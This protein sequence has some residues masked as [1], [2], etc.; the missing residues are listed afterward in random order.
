MRSNL[1]CFLF[2]FVMICY[3]YIYIIST[4]GIWVI[5]YI[6]LIH[7]IF[8]QLQISHI[9]SCIQFPRI[10]SC[11]QFPRTPIS[12]TF[13]FRAPLPVLVGNHHLNSHQR[14]PWSAENQ[15]YQRLECIDCLFMIF[16][17]LLLKKSF[18]KAKKCVLLFFQFH[19]I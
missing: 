9:F 16:L 11:I 19:T 18:I 5:N 1:Q 8:A 17:L 3:I 6:T 7:L 10:F 2:V 15:L 4:P 14:F 13:I 12:H